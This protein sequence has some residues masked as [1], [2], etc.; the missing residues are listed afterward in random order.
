MMPAA[1][2]FA[3]ND[4]G[5]AVKIAEVVSRP[6]PSCPMEYAMLRYSPVTVSVLTFSFSIPG[7]SPAQ[8]AFV[9]GIGAEDRVYVR[10]ETSVRVGDQARTTVDAGT[11][12]IV[13][14][15]TGC[16]I[17]WS[18]WCCTEGRKLPAARAARQLFG[19]WNT[20]WSLAHI[21]RFLRPA[22]LEAKTEPESAT[23]AGLSQF[24]D[25]T[26]NYPQLAA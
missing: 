15:V 21:L 20:E 10:T 11:V 4:F 8:M 23:K 9:T 19:K 14:S 6:Q 7:N 13:R 24:L 5:T 25:D 18:S 17:C 1:V 12:L 16:G 2:G 26:K 3:G 22:I